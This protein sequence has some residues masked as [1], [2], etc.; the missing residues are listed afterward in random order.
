MLRTMDLVEPFVQL[1]PKLRNNLAHGSTTL[2]PTSIATLRLL[3]DAINQIFPPE[4]SPSSLH[5]SA[6]VEEFNYFLQRRRRC[7][8]A[9]STGC[10]RWPAAGRD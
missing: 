9:D 5:P 7:E 1:T 10:S 8:Q 6:I 4:L 2:T 3:A